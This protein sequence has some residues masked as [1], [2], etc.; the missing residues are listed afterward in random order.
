MNHIV[1]FLPRHPCAVSSRLPQK[2]RDAHDVW[3]LIV[4]FDRVTTLLWECG[5]VRLH[6]NGEAAMLRTRGKYAQ[7]TPQP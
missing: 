5:P 3:D 4:F 1:R 6:G 2:P 7:A